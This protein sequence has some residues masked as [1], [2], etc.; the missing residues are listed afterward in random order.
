M[1]EPDEFVTSTGKV[2][3][4][5]DFERLAD[6]AQ[7]GWTEPTDAERADAL[8]VGLRVTTERL[9]RLA[10]CAAAA[11]ERADVGDADEATAILKEVVTLDGRY[12]DAR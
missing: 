8:Q 9:G 4:D 3:T 6:E 7:E 12:I 2:L 5:V 10:R 1:P 11:L